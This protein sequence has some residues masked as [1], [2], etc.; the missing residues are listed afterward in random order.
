MAHKILGLF[1]LTY[2]SIPN[3]QV[4]NSIFLKCKPYVYPLSKRH[5]ATDNKELKEVS[6]AEVKRI[7]DEANKN[8]SII[9]VRQP[10]ELRQT[11]VIP[12]SINIP[13]DQVKDALNNLTADEFKKKYGCDRPEKNS[14]IIFSCKLGMRSA[15]AQEIAE[16]LGY[17]MAKNYRGGWDDWEERLKKQK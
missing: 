13:L 15:A 8:V 16:K 10:E 5:F 2:Y 14:L 6:Y 9:D 17:K 12:G 4:P 7:C 1:K 11:G 3:T